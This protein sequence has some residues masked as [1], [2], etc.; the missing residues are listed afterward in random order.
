MTVYVD[1]L[2]L[3]GNWKYG[4]SCHLL[5]QDQSA[6]ALAEL[7]HFAAQVGMK[8]EWFQGSERWPH[9]DLTSRRREMALAYGAVSVR[10]RDWMSRQHALRRGEQPPPLIPIPTRGEQMALAL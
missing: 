4:E 3:W 8:P 2:K 1:E 7:H 9:Y 5:P 6:E 10:S